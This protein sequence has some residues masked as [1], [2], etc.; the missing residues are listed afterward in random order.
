LNQ[1]AKIALSILAP[2]VIWGMPIDWIPLQAITVV[3][4]R[5]LAIFAMAVLCWVLE[6]IPI[7]ATSLLVIV[8]ELVIIS[9][10][11]FAPLMG[12]AGNPEF[13][14][15]LSYREVMATF[16][17]PV[18]MLFLGGFFLAMAATKYRLDTNLAR[19]LLKPFGR[20][21]RMILLGL[22]LI[23]GLFSMFM[24]NTATTAMMLAILTPVL[25]AF[26][27]GDTGKIAFALGIP[28][29][30]NIGG[31]GTPI[32]TPPNAVA[33]KYLVGEN[34]I[35]FGQWM[36]FALP[37]VLIVLAFAWLLLLRVFPP[38]AEEIDIEIKGKFLRNWRALTA[39]ATAAGTIVL[40]LTDAWHGMN[41][42]VVAMVPVAVFTATR[43]VTAED[44]RRISWDVLWLVAGGI[45][46]GLGLERTGLAGHLVASIPFAQLSP[47]LIVLVVS[48]L[49]L[50]MSTLTS[51]TA[52]ANLLLPIAAALGASLPGLQGL[53]GE[54][55]LILIVAFACSLA[56]ALP[57]S[58]P[59]N[60]M[61]HATG[62]IDSRQ[63]V[64]VGIV[65][66]IVGL[67][68]GYGLMF[69]LRQVGFL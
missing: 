63:M 59:P 19:I 30:A 17:S 26:E 7:F 29:A 39:Y 13:G 5:L 21:P 23:T 8:A 35:G 2:L 6:P 36:A 47:Y 68:G 69:V 24:S 33:M 9:D 65:I 60:A 34:A 64:R 15:L 1:K 52:T 22:M 11:G 62:L 61:A 46:L 50:V 44:L 25:A 31:I 43:I 57:I 3:E 56:M 12:A 28:F 53:G 48:G 40:W 66:G 67:M 20:N 58:T 37:Y 49:A 16:A 51:N 14:E 55:G 10:K 42:Y 18:I 38:R 54:K 27:E 32:G 41:S 45:A 4:Q